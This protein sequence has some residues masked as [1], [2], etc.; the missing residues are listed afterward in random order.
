MPAKQ[1]QQ[2]SHA[3]RSRVARNGSAPRSSS[4]AHKP[5]QI[6][7]VSVVLA[8][9][10]LFAY[11]AVRNDDFVNFDDPSYILRNPQVQQGVTVHSV[12]WAFTTFYASNWHPLTWISHMIDWKLYGKN[13]RGHHMTSVALHAAN[14]ILLF[15]L[16]L[17]MTG[18]T[19]RSA[20]VAFFFALHPAHV[21]SVAWIAERKDIL[22]AF[23]FLCA[24][25]ATAC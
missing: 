1:P 17:Y 25:L 8:V 5:W 2:K 18:F 15:L 7:V 4:A 22:C 24:L 23:F 19:G 16:L 13:P 12:K 11:R 6:F 14:A 10:T 20:M 21:E 9:V 3:K